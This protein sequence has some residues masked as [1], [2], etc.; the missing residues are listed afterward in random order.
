MNTTLVLTLIASCMLSGA[1]ATSV[2]SFIYEFESGALLSGNFRGFETLP[3]AQGPSVFDGTITVLPIGLSATFNDF[4][5][6]VFS[7]DTEIL[8][9]SSS[10]A[11]LIGEGET[12]FV[13]LGGSRMDFV[14]S[15]GSSGPIQIFLENGI[16]SDGGVPMALNNASTNNL[17]LVDFSEEFRPSSWSLSV[18]PEPSGILLLLSSVVALINLGR[19]R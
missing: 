15:S 12:A 13:S 3:S 19:R 10:Q 18:V 11:S 2:Y 7:W 5:G 4:S 6:T 16:Q 9:D 17:L 14:L 1:H 8:G